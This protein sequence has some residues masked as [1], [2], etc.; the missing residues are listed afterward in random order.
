MQQNASKT[1]KNFIGVAIMI[2]LSKLLGFARDVLLAFFYGVGKLNDVYTS[3]FGISSLLFTS[4][5][6]AI[7]SVII[8]D[9]TYYL[10]KCSREERYRYIY[11]LLAQ[12]TM[13]AA[14]ISVL[15][16]IGAPALS[17]LLMGSEWTEQMQGIATTL[18]RIMMPTLLFVSLTYLAMGI[19]QVHGRFILSS[20]VSVPF[21]LLVIITLLL[22]RNDII[23]LGVVTALGW[24]LQFIIQLPVLIREGYHPFRHIDFKNPHTVALFKRLVPILLGNSLIQL[25]LIIDRSFGLRIG[26]SS[27]SML[28]FGGTLFITITSIFIVAISTVVFPRLS[29][30][31]LA[32]NYAGIRRMLSYAFRILLFILLPYILLVVAYHQDILSL[33]YQHGNFPSEATLP[34]AKIF[35]IYS[36]AVPGYVCQ[37]LFNRVFYSLKN[38][39]IPMVVSSACLLL[40]LGANCLLYETFGLIAIAG[41]TVLIMWLYAITMGFLIQRKVGGF[42]RRDYLQFLVELLLPLAAL[43]IVMGLAPLVFS[44][45]GEFTF[46]FPTMIG[47]GLYLFVAWKTGLNKIFMINDDDDDDDWE[48]LF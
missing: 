47:G 36:F 40:N 32:Q 6:T 42:I 26:E 30:Y 2:F 19:L 5:G 44:P 38:F 7:S 48:E 16:I 18:I 24:L 41:S 10:D 27:A 25:S 31:S 37:E 4:I 45:W 20:A 43:L 11:S 33:I 21:N 29:R 3:V 34:T 8:P 17:Y 22:N 15:G 23:L 35:L 14:L 39:K 12:V 28:Y 46:I 1:G 13:L 9:L